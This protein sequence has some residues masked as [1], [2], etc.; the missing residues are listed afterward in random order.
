MDY[1]KLKKMQNIIDKIDNQK[2]AIHHIKMNSRL[3]LEMKHNININPSP[4]SIKEDIKSASPLPFMG[5]RVEIDEN[6]DSWAAFDRDG[7]LISE[8]PKE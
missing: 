4:P 3:Y 2:P 1:E 5:V 8:P 7:K 6:M